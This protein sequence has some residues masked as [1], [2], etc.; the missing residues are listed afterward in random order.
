MKNYRSHAAILDYPNQKF[1]DGEL[2]VCGAASTINAFI[3]SPL[4]VSSE[5]P[6]VF[7]AISGRNDREASSPSY[8]NID[9]AIQIKAYV[10]SLLR[11]RGVRE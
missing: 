9:E 7:H 6:V 11:E 8:F 3:G 2:E 4:L 10:V 5:F 1:Y